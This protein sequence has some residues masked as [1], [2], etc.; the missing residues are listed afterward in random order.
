MEASVVK[1]KLDYLKLSNLRQKD[2]LAFLSR[3]EDAL[4][5]HEMNWVEDDFLA[6]QAENILSKALL[7][8][9]KNDQG[10]KLS[11][12][13]LLAQ[14]DEERDLAFRR[15]RAG[16]KLYQSSRSAEEQKAYQRLHDEVQPLRL[17][18]NIGYFK[19]TGKLQLL[20]ARLH[21]PTLEEALETLGLTDFV[22]QLE[23]AQNRF[24]D[25]YSQRY[26]DK[27]ELIKIN[28]PEVRRDI[29]ES[30][31]DFCDYVCLRADHR[32]DSNYGKLFD[33]L[34]RQRQSSIDYL[35]RREA[36]KKRKAKQV[37]TE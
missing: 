32:P 18:T 10:R 25:L 28:L 26:E 5:K 12:T 23:L 1:K 24:D 29:C 11:V 2:F 16:I 3:L 7:F 30:H 36:W 19:K 37:A 14:A 4:R 15:L 20:V 27:E 6:F 35:R 22:A 31:H 21:Q 8:S 33:A 17:V 13:P 9:Q 34:N